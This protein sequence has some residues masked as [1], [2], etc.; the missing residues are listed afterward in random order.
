MEITITK[1]DIVWSYVGQFF[2]IAAGFLTLPLILHMLST[3]EIAMNYLMLSVSTLVAL[4]D[5][6]FTP[7]INRLVSYVYSGATALSKE[8][9]RVEHSDEVCYSLLFKLIKVTK[10][11]FNRISLIA[12]LLLLTFG[13]W[14]M[15]SVTEGFTNVD[16]SL[17]IW[18]V[19]SFST[20]F[21]I[22]YKYYDAL[23]VGRGF[24]KESKKTVLYSKVFN[25]VLVFV[26]LLCGI[27]L[28][29]VCIA[30]LL[31]P[32]L[33]RAMAHY[34]FYDKDTKEQLSGVK[35]EQKEEK[36][37]FDAIWYNAK[38]TGINF[39]G[40]YCTRQFGMFISGL[41]LSAQ[42]IA[43]YGL[44][45]QLVSILS[46][47]SSTMLNT[48]LPKIISFR[49]SGDREN[50]I[51]TFS[52]TIVVYQLLFIIGAITIVLL[53][54]WA[55]CLI[56]SNASLPA[57][58]ILLLF[59][60]IN[61]LEEHHSNFAIFITTGNIIPFVPAALISGVLICLGDYLMLMFTDLG[62]FG[63]VFVQGIIQLAYNNWRWP[64]WVFNEYQIS[65]FKFQKIGF[66]ELYCASKKM[67]SRYQVSKVPKM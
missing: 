55:L 10:K 36:E 7:Q 12:L 48:Y 60:I 15:Y 19:F 27:G 62:L 8:G 43:S 4:M 54:P 9:Y 58:S 13:T 52:F 51:K 3:E 21:T 6:G 30:N 24:I 39:I 33:G 45:M 56:R 37:I 25:I 61:F 59:I 46:T 63:I 11:I 34:Y 44:M 22:Y 49:I 14:Y 66:V 23:L 42:V 41:F 26:L 50:T 35:V 32:F 2:N 67:K 20:Y 5:F 31:S 29:G 47:I 64:K 18:A 57:M 1:K 38:K 40:T 28:L 53:G 17:L 16:N 65:L